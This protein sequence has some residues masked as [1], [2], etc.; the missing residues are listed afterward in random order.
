MPK[1]KVN[2]PFKV[3]E[4]SFYDG[5]YI[6]GEQTLQD[7]SEQ[8]YEC[9]EE[10][11]ESQELRTKLVELREKSLSFGEM[12]VKASSNLSHSL[13]LIDHVS[14]R[15]K[16]ILNKISKLEAGYNGWEAGDDRDYNVIRKIEEERDG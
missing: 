7:I 1:I 4:H 12:L 15:N 5:I 3:G 14:D 13:K 8:Y 2:K 16:D 9:F 6:I 11:E 10:I